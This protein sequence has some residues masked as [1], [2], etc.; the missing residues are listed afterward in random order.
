MAHFPLFVKLKNILVVGAG[1]V[2]SRKIE[3]LLEFIED[4]GKMIIVAPEICE[5]AQKLISKNENKIIFRQKKFEGTDLNDIQLVFA[6]TSSPQTDRL[7]SD[8]CRKKNIPANIADIPDLCDFYFPAIV[9]RGNLVVG[10]NTGRDC[11]ALAKKV[12]ETISR[13]LPENT[14]EKLKQLALLRKQL[15]NAGIK[16]GEN[17]EYIKSV[18]EA[19]K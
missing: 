14:D 15:L 3:T 6:A 11:P 1:N 4:N 12:R 7:I 18:N 9:K 8:L 13:T 2:A 16:P 5:K 19:L 10:I 17:S